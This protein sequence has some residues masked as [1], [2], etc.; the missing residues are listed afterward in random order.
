MIAN[1]IKWFIK[2]YSD[3]MVT[4]EELSRSYIH[5]RVRP[6]NITKLMSGKY[7]V[8]LG[9][10]HCVQGSSVIDRGKSVYTLCLDL[11]PSMLSL[12]KERFKDLMLEF[13]ACDAT[14]IPLRDK[15]INAL[16]SIA[17][18]HHLTI[19]ELMRA[20]NEIKRVVRKG[21]M[22]LIT[23]WSPW[24]SRFLV[25]LIAMYLMKLLDIR[26][27]PRE[28]LIPWRSKS[29]KLLRYYILYSLDELSSIMNRLGLKVIS[30]GYFKPYLRSSNNVYIVALNP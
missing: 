30:S 19:N 6:W 2:R 14:A 18:L 7:V 16:L 27:N 4:Y 17:A 10:G 8:D 23:T 5:W 9:S 29:R 26:I 13:I 22:I 1:L 11:S 12:G 21:G 20:L 15:S 24:Q 25:R 28:F 3:I